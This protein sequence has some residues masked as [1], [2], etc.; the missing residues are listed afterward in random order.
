MSALPPAHPG[1]AADILAAADA[2]LSKDVWDDQSARQVAQGQGNN[3]VILFFQH[4]S[5]RPTSHSRDHLIHGVPNISFTGVISFTGCPPVPLNNLNGPTSYLHR[6]RRSH[7]CKPHK[8]CRHNFQRRRGVP[9]SRCRQPHGRPA[10][11]P[12]VPCSVTPGRPRQP[13]PTASPSPT[14]PSSC[15]DCPSA[16]LRRLRHHRPRVLSGGHST[17]APLRSQTWPR[18]LQQLRPPGTLRLF[19]PPVRRRD[20]QAPHSSAWSAASSSTCAVARSGGIRT[21]ERACVRNACPV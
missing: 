7:H 8:A 9:A 3:K 1:G 6:I 14:R 15:R 10:A 18:Q 2:Q 13:R 19:P 11:R 4:G 12:P 5:T 16:K 21:G 17:R 20:Q